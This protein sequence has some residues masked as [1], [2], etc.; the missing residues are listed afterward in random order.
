M[1]GVCCHPGRMKGLKSGKTK[2]NPRIKNISNHFAVQYSGYS[3][4]S[5]SK[6]IIFPLNLKQKANIINNLVTQH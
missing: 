4:V 5:F 3:P 6:D 1:V 2:R